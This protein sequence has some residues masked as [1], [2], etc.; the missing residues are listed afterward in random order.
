MLLSGHNKITCTKTNQQL[1]LC[2]FAHRRICTCH[3]PAFPTQLPLLRHRAAPT[4]PTS[5]FAVSPPFDTKPG[6]SLTRTHTYSPN[7]YA[8]FAVIPIR[9][10]LCYFLH[11]RATNEL[12]QRHND[13]LWLHQRA[14]LAIPRLRRRH[15]CATC[16]DYR[17]EVL[18]AHTGCAAYMGIRPVL[19]VCDV[20]GMLCY[21]YF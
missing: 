19:A 3:A 12:R 6:Q 18:P 4:Y 16:H 2:E 20:A 11:T 10:Y 17:H 9:R 15:C 14:C 21:L 5:S 8:P 7:R 13:V 1:V